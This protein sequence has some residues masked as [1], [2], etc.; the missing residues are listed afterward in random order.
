MVTKCAVGRL[1]IATPSATTKVLLWVVCKI[2]ASTQVNFT[3][4][5]CLRNYVH[6]SYFGIWLALFGKDIYK[7]VSLFCPKHTYQIQHCTS[8]KWQICIPIIYLGRPLCW[9]YVKLLNIATEWVQYSIV[10]RSFLYAYE[11]DCDGICSFMWHYHR[12]VGGR[13]V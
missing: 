2:I 13:G 11:C 9:T 7:S 4:I 12:A 5:I 10:D 8:A 6:V 3:S 1:R